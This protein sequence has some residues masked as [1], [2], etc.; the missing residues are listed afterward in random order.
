M[1]RDKKESRKVVHAGKDG[2]QRIHNDRNHENNGNK[3]SNLTL[4][5]NRDG[6]VS[7][8]E[9]QMEQMRQ[10]LLFNL[11]LI[12]QQKDWLTTKDEQIAHLKDQNEKLRSRLERLERRITL[13]RKGNL[14]RRV[15][16]EEETLESIQ[17]IEIENDVKETKE[18]NE[19]NITGFRN[20][21]YLTTKLPY[22]HL[23]HIM[24]FC[25]VS[26]FQNVPPIKVANKD[27]DVLVPKWRVCDDSNDMLPEDESN[28]EPEEEEA[29]TLSDSDYA[30]RHWKHELD[31]KRRKRWDLQR[32]REEQLKENLRRRSEEKSTSKTLPK[33][34]KRKSLEEQ[35]ITSFDPS[36]NNIKGICV[37]DTIPVVAFGSTIPI[38]PSS[39]FSL[40]WFNESKVD[41]DND[42]RSAKK[43]R[44]SR[45]NN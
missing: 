18:S 41:M 14:R 22:R 5:R 23:D 19:M 17:S 15:R 8:V 36:V 30:K 34:R 11:E 29:E 32:I 20:A 39:E 28:A 43:R 38:F 16:S 35:R 24:N 9:L 37:E 40:P 42:E 31:E 44:K 26:N 25:A 6:K 12:Q 33:S 7:R 1:N 10:L 13:E 2:N 4:M 45:R 27:D 3:H 21:N